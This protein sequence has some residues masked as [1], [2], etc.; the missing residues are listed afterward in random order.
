MCWQK[1]TGEDDS[2]IVLVLVMRIG[3]MLVS[4]MYIGCM[5][6]FV[7]ESLVFVSV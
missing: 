2:L 1:S 3:S 7:L 4:V 5:L 6:V